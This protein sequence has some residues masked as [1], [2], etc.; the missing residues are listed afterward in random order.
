MNN[1]LIEHTPSIILQKYI[2]A[3]WFFRNNPNKKINFP[4]VPDG[5]SDIVFYLHDSKK[6]GNLKKTFATGIMGNAKLIII[7]NG[8]ELF[9]IRFKPS[10]LSYFLKNDISKLANNIM[11]L[12]QINISIFNKIKIDPYAEDK[13]IVLEIEKQLKQIFKKINIK[14]NFIKAVEEISVNS[15]VLIENV[16]KKYNFSLKNLPR[17]FRKKIGLTPKKFARIMRF[18]K[19]HKKI[20]KKG[21]KNLIVIALSSGYFDQAHF[22]KEYQKLVGYNPSNETLSILYNKPQKK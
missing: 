20:T 22:N 14:D 6:F 1:I 13:N 19:A 11:E 18:Q 3:Y 8:M 4:V 15:Q 2:D 5:C 17:I 10:I 9:G 7:P 16:A 12:S 21:L